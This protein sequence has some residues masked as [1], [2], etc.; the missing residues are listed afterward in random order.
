ME[1]KTWTEIRKAADAAGFYHGWMGA[2]ENAA[3]TIYV[4]K[5]RPAED[6]DAVALA[7]LEDTLACGT[8]DPAEHEFF[9]TLGIKF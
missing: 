3:E 8:L 9:V 2:E 6:F 4:E 1:M 7:S 5:A